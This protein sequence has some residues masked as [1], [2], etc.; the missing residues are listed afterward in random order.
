MKYL[1]YLLGIIAI[2]F[3]GFILLGVVKPEV[4]YDCE[5]TINKPIAEAWA[6]TQD[7][8]KLGEWL[9]G[10]QRIEHI[11]GTPGSVGS[12]NDVYFDYNGEVMSIRETITEIV[13]DESISMHYASDFM[14]MDYAMRLTA[15]DG[16][17]RINSST[18][19][20]GN[21][22]FSKSL[23]ALMGS[24][25]R[26]QEETN[27][28]ALKATIEKNTKQYSTMNMTAGTQE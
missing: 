13:P 17:T 14:D 3:I 26:T 4:S 6:V 16:K 25:L 8:E 15:V 18:T 19:A 10:F 7:E 22:I 20:K 1:K 23:M 2:L 5:I 27:L 9:P 21:G 24:G 12:V 28:N 11:S